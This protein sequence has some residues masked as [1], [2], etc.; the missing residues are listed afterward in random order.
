M[1]SL[2]SEAKADAEQL[3]EPLGLRLPPR[4]WAHQQS[5]IT[6]PEY[7]DKGFWNQ[8]YYGSGDQLFDWYNSYDALRPLFD[9]YA[10]KDGAIL[11]VGCGNS[12]LGEQMYDDG[13]QNITNIDYSEPVVQLM[14]RRSQTTRPDIKYMTMDCRRM[15]FADKTFDLVFDKGTLDAIVCGSDALDNV[16]AM[17]KE[18]ARVLK[19]SGVYI[20]MSYGAPQDRLSYL[21]LEEYQWSVTTMVIPKPNYADASSTSSS[22]N[23]SEIE[24]VN[25]DVINADTH[26]YIY[27]M[28]KQVANAEAANPEPARSKA[29]AKKC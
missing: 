27:I 10:K 15:T 6:M 2:G 12:Q 29:P 14:S 19:D 20:I 28:Q 3:L 1:L 16:G 24:P 8:R 22:R 18:I 26:H 17:C 25:D 4:G 21:E 13:Y 11:Q 7:G 5:L 9:Q 23:T